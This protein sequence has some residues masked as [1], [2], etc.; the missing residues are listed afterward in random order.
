MPYNTRRKSLSLPS[1]GIHLPQTNASRA[2][3]AAAAAATRSPPSQTATAPSSNATSIEQPPPSKRAK[4]SHSSPTPPVPTSVRKT[5]RRKPSQ[6]YNHTPPPSPGPGG[7]SPLTSYVDVQGISD[8]I[9]VAV[10]KQLEKTANK[11]HLIKELASILA[12]SLTVVDNSANPQAIISSRLNSYLKRPWTALSP[13]PLAKELVPSHPR[14]IY[15]YLTTVPHQP[16]PETDS[17]SPLNSRRSIISPSVSD[18]DEIRK[19]MELSPSPEVDLSSPDLDDEN[20][21][22]TPAGSFS[23]HSN[24]AQEQ[25]HAARILA[26]NPHR[27]V[28]PPLEGDEKEF[29]Q[30]ASSMQA[31]SL[32]QVNSP[33][34]LG[35]V[36]IM[37]VEYSEE[38]T[39]PADANETEDTAVV[40]NR[41][42]AAALF[43]PGNDIQTATLSSPALKPTV[44]NQL[45]PSFMARRQLEE[46][47]IDTK[48]HESTSI[49]GE[50]FG[51]WGGDILSPENVD[52]DELDNMLGG[53]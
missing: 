30:T 2:A 51:G 3:A 32:S 41:E 27:A 42:T 35:D 39:T 7:C 53:Y 34:A 13:C 46:M 20:S 10:I 52:L 29:S 9:V 18:E 36:D 17:L 47:V 25:A 16:L 48:R 8:Q 6:P 22:P 4:R 26:A 12:E 11:P 44:A 50:E 14:R 23:P 24:P 37:E 28:S 15:F 21:P 43:G 40:R 33:S 49:L 5:H 45:S 1:L 19:R 31:R 38:A